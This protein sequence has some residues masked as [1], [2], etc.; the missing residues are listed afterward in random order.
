MADVC[1]FLTL[2]E[3]CMQNDCV[4]CTQRRLIKPI[5]FCNAENKKNNMDIELQIQ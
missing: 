4:R 2:V 3:L 5:R 1:G